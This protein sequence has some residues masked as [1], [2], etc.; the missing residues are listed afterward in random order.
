MSVYLVW[1]RAHI[2]VEGNE[3]AD[4]AANKYSWK[5]DILR[6]PNTATPSGIKRISKETRREWR[7]ETTFGLSHSNY[8]KWARQSHQLANAAIT[9]RTVTTSLSPAPEQNARG[10][11]L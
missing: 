9:N 8:A 2:G 11:N 6:L 1:V 4:K 10:F 5:G 3:E 7:H